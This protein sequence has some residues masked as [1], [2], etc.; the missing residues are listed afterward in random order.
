MKKIA[1]TLIALI[2]LFVVIPVKAQSAESIWLTASTSSFKTGETVII[3]VNGASAS[4]IQGLTFQIKF[5]PACLQPVN[6]AS[7]IPGM[8]GLSLPQIN[9]LV[10]ASFASTT[11]QIANGVLAEVRFITLGACQTNVMLESAALVIKNESGFAAPLPGVSLN[12]NPVPLA[13]SAERGSSQDTPLLGTPL[14]LGIEP[15]PS[16]S[17]FL[18]TGTMIVLSIIGVLLLVGIFVLIRILRGENTHG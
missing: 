3:T 16:T 14:P 2:C 7:P 10:D 11:P 1:L 12:E 9:G 8:N 5:D 18:P 13:I 4:P 15:K 6:A 17:G